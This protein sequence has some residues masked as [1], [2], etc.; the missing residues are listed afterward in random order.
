M[1]SVPLLE[2]KKL[3]TLYVSVIL[4]HC[5]PTSS[6][7]LPVLSSVQYNGA[8]PQERDTNMLTE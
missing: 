2:K 6:E 8:A 5:Y 1:T 3:W 4:P 7:K